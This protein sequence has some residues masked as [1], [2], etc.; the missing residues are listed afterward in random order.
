MLCA[1]QGF[2]LEVCAAQVLPFFIMRRR[3]QTISGRF[4]ANTATKKVERAMVNSKVKLMSN[5][6]NVMRDPR[7]FFLS[8][9]PPKGF[10]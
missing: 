2:F 1:T 3:G 5:Q 10:F 7:I 8:Y 6:K 9:V 4:P